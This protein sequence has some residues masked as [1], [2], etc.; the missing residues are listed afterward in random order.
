SQF[1]ANAGLYAIM[2]KYNQTNTPRKIIL[3]EMSDQNLTFTNL[4]CYVDYVYIGHSCIMGVIRT[5]HNQIQNI[6]TTIV[7]TTVTPTGAPPT[8]LSVTTT[9]SAPSTAKTITTINSAYVKLR[10]LSSGSV[11][12]LDPIY[13]KLNT[14]LPT[15]TFRKL[16]LGG[17]VSIT[18]TLSG[19]NINYDFDLYDENDKLIS[20]NFPFK[21]IVGS[22][23]GI[24]NILNNNKMIVALNETTTSW[25]LLSIET[26]ILSQY[27]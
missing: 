12:S 11:L 9:I 19:R 27:S 6:T 13:P 8:V 22:A 25:S 24:F 14:T 18:H 7:T 5:Q 10:F 17:Y 21:P 1:S 15:L 23:Y 2:L 3:H 4:Y 26:P 20:Y 16:P